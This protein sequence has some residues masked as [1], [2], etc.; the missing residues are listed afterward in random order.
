MAGFQAEAQSWAD[1][2]GVTMLPDGQV[3]ISIISEWAGAARRWPRFTTSIRKAGGDRVIDE[4]LSRAV[5]AYIRNSGFG[6]PTQ[7]PESVV[8][9]FGAEASERLMPRL[10]QLAREAVY[11]PVDWQQHDDVSAVRAVEHE[12]AEQYPE[13]DADAVSALGWY[14]SYCNK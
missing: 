13:L 12:I 8:E 10:Q 11:W 5:V 2:G 9:A 1:S 6:W 7:T 3:P 4:E 14:F